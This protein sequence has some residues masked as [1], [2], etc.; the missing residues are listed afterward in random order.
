M[1]FTG[2]RVNLTGTIR[3]SG[4]PTR[5]DF[6]IDGQYMTRFENIPEVTNSA[7]GDIYLLYTMADF[8]NLSPAE[9]TLKAV[10]VGADSLFVVDFMAYEPSTAV[11]VSSTSVSSNSSALSTSSSTVSTTQ[12]FS[13]VS[14]SLSTSPSS[15]SSSQSAHSTSSIAVDTSQ[16]LA[17]EMDVPASDSHVSYWPSGA[18]SPYSDARRAISCLEGIMSSS[19]A[20]S[21][22]TYN[23]T[24]KSVPK[25]LA[26]S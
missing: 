25:L 16:P 21:Y 19:T 3:H 9:H 8:D 12:A 4:E 14:T 24:G 15:F 20:G 6:Y 26:L 18:W 2:T 11:P 17:A 23:F 5:V 22:L 1:T 7:S 10:S 13:S